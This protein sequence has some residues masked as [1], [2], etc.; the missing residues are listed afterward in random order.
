LYQAYFDKYKPDV[1][2]NGVKKVVGFGGAGGMQKKE[3][4]ILPALNMG[5]GDKTVTID[6]VSVLQKKITPAEVFFGN[7]GQD[8]TNKFNEVIYN[9]KYMYVKCR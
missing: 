5:I 6:S 2:K 1:L 3:V 4:F 7:I 8:L 9:F